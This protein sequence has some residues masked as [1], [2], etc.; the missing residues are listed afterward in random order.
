[1]L[2]DRVW[3]V[4]SASCLLATVAVAHPLTPALLD[5]RELEGGR[6]AVFWKSS[7]LRAPGALVAP[8]LPPDCRSETAPQVVSDGESAVKTWTARCASPGLVGRRVGVTGLGPARIDA[9]VR[10]TLADGRVVRGVVRDAE[11]ALTV[12]ARQPWTAIA[13]GY[14]RLGVE[15]ILTGFDHLL[16]VAGLL[17][18][19]RGRRLLLETIT[20]FTV[21]HSITL[22]IAVL[23]LVRVPSRAIELAIAC[24]VFALA[25]ELTREP[26]EPPSRLRRRPWAMA[27]VFGLLHG[28]GFASALREVGLPA[29]DVPLALVAFNAGIE[30]GQLAFVAVVLAV[31]AI[32]TRV[33]L[34]CPRWLRRVPPYA[35]GSL[36]AFWCFERAAAL[37]R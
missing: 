34:A 15:H 22:S 24:S 13:A 18:L 27:L 32:A 17:M 31:S 21:G 25:A 33:P 4:A 11:P 6:L 8:E 19:V 5:V 10:V 16:F 7:L 30:V 20:A 9:L 2:W 26:A 3:R 35:M 28:L 1:M 14:G 36:A 37:M 12:P 29:G 23:D